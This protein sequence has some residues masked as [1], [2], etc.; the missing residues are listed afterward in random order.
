MLFQVGGQKFSSSEFSGKQHYILHLG[1]EAL[2]HPRTAL[3]FSISAAQG[4][5]SLTYQ[6]L[7]SDGNYVAGRPWWKNHLRGLVFSFTVWKQCTIQ[8]SS[9]SEKPHC[10]KWQLAQSCAAI[11]PPSTTTLPDLMW[12]HRLA[13]SRITQ[14]QPLSD[15]LLCTFSNFLV[16]EIPYIIIPCFSSCH[17]KSECSVALRIRAFVF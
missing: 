14:S 7:H 2:S 6:L 11:S 16:S 5:R 17:R 8:G 10:L 1:G 4:E 13:S 9:I 15:I 12:P 3:P